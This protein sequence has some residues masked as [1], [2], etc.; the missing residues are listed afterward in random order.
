MQV[1]VWGVLVGSPGAANVFT[2]GLEVELCVHTER[3]VV[4]LMR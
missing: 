3:E 1:Q 2:Q 4:R